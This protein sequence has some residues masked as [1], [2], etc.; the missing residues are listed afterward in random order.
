M[1]GNTM[2]QSYLPQNQKIAFIQ[3]GWHADIVAEGRKTFI[4]GLEKAGIA[5]EKVEIFD[6]PGSLEIPLQAKYL[7]ESGE[8]AIIIASGFI[9][10]GGIYRHDFVASTVI[11]GMMR[12]Q[13]D[14]GVPI[15]SV[16]LTP[17][18]FHES[19]P[20]HRFFFEHFKKKGEEAAEACL[21][22]LENMSRFKVLEKAA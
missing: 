12:V 19:E 11:D 10:N 16:V 8:Y 3:A 7:A 17:H 13:L 14:T 1:K 22:T 15:L 18:H 20:H 9:I 2:D 5:K 21:K 6:V 4:A